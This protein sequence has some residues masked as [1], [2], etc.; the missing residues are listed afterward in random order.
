[1]STLCTVNSLQYVD[2][3]SAACLSVA[4][5][6]SDAGRTFFLTR[7]EAIEAQLARNYFGKTGSLLIFFIAFDCDQGPA[8]SALSG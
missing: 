8:T 6:F 2:Q 1:M 4:A 7:I 5:C 3:T